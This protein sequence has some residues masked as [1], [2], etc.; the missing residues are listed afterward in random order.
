M[1]SGAKGNSTTDANSALRTFHSSKKDIII[2]KPKQ[3]TSLTTNSE[4]S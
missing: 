2:A 1:N 4:T 3:S